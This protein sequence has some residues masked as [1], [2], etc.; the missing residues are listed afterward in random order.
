MVAQTT[1]HVHPDERDDMQHI[2]TQRLLALRVI[3][4]P[5]SRLGQLIE[6]R[7]AQLYDELGE[8]I[9]PA[10]RGSRTLPGQANQEGRTAANT[11]ISGDGAAA[12]SAAAGMEQASALELGNN[13]LT[14]SAELQGRTATQATALES[15]AATITSE[16]PASTIAA[17]NG[18]QLQRERMRQSVTARLGQDGQINW[19]WMLSQLLK[20]D[21][22]RLGLEPDE[23]DDI[24]VFLIKNEARK[25]DKLELLS[26]LPDSLSPEAVTK[27]FEDIR[28]MAAGYVAF[29]MVERVKSELETGEEVKQ[30]P[31]VPRSVGGA[32]YGIPMIDF[33]PEDVLKKANQ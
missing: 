8:E 29:V 20:T 22:K 2:Q 19:V 27:I 33:D 13:N 10:K 14:Q 18:V 30:M 32:F 4:P 11:D 26:R 1:N 31:E 17:G 5:K 28:T 9:D 16:A 23:F 6:E 25:F 21:L 24:R 12:Q 15:G 3:A 7:L